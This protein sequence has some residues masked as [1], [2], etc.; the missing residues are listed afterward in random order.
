MAEQEHTVGDLANKIRRRPYSALQHNC[1]TKSVEFAGRCADMGLEAKVVLCLAI[2]HLKVPV[3]GFRVPFLGPHCYAEVLGRQYEVS[4]E[5]KNEKQSGP[6]VLARLKR[7][8]MPCSKSSQS[9]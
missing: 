3:L 7:F 6:R 4:H 8:Q 9:N 5:S 1:L 2:F